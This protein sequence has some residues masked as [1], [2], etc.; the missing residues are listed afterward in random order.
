MMGQSQAPTNSE[1]N[2]CQLRFVGPVLCDTEICVRLAFSNLHVKHAVFHNR[3]YCSLMLSEG[4]GSHP[5][6]VCVKHLVFHTK[7]E[8]AS[9]FFTSI[10]L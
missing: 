3:T 6:G 8:D 1:N 5:S 10:G 4:E 2:G 7:L 9:V